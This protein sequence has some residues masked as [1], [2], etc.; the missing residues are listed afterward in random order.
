MDVPGRFPS[1]WFR[2]ETG[3]L[4]LEKLP[5]PL[6]QFGSCCCCMMGRKNIPPSFFPS[7][8]KSTLTW[9]QIQMNNTRAVDEGKHDFFLSS[10]HLKFPLMP[11]QGESFGVWGLQHHAPACESRE[12]AWE[13]TGETWWGE[14]KTSKCDCAVEGCS[15]T[16]T[17]I[18]GITRLFNNSG[19]KEKKI[20]CSKRGCQMTGR[21]RTQQICPLYAAVLYS[22]I[23]QCI[24][25]YMTIENQKLT[26][27]TLTYSHISS[28]YDT[29]N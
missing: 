12:R 11:L 22:A 7:S 26:F 9:I 28:W 13:K 1:E 15:P 14:R 23:Y 10:H 2:Q 20:F 19:W 6:C 4:S 27:I 21:R 5:N 24:E 29:C 16:F 17:I 3:C 25:K 8:V 18:L